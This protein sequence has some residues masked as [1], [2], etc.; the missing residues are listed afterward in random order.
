MEIKKIL[1]GASVLLI[2]A[3]LLFTSVAVT[4]DTMNEKEE[5]PISLSAYGNQ[6]IMAKSNPENSGYKNCGTPVLWDNGLPDGRNG[7]SCF[8]MPPTY[9]REIIDDFTVPEGGWEV[10]GGHFRVVP[11]SATDPSAI[12]AVR[13]FFYPSI[14]ECVP[15]TEAF[16]VLDATHTGYLTG[17][18][19]FDRPEIAIDCFFDC[20][21]LTPG[22]WW[23]CF[24][25]RINDNC[26][27]LTALG[28]G[29]SIYA[30][31]PDDPEVPKWTPG[32]V[33]FQGQLYD[34]SFRLTGPY[35]PPE[36]DLECQGSGLIYEDQEPGAEGAG[37]IKVCNYGGEGSKMN[38]Y[39]DTADVP[40]WGTWSFAPESGTDVL[41]GSC[42]IISV[43]VV[44]TDSEGEYNGVLKIYNAD[45]ASDYCEVTTSVNIVK[46]RA[47]TTQHQFLINLLE[48]FPALNL[49]LKIIFGA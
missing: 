28:Y 21:N 9:N 31:F 45:N 46:P 24:Q 41:D 34:C 10:C 49:I 1:K 2:A 6:E 20:V 13:V 42:D 25:P 32:S 40:T 23:V 22:E 33:V 7:L 30:S 48:Q 5:V 18:Y 27:W 44:F 15:D 4:A 37:Q 12:T 16:A 38:W 14:D 39:I 19:Y 36:P 8:Y 35:T 11:N 47:R 3:T 43:D 29:C 17:A 26:F